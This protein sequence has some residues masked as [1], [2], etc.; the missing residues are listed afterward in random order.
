MRPLYFL[1]GMLVGLCAGVSAFLVG[2][3]LLI[4]STIEYAALTAAYLVAVAVGGFLGFFALRHF[5]IHKIG[6]STAP[7]SGSLVDSIFRLIN[8]ASQ[9]SPSERYDEAN[10]L[11]KSGAVWFASSMGFYTLLNSIVAVVAIF[12]G[13]VASLLLFQQNELISEQ[14][15]SDLLQAVLAE[16]ARRSIQ[17]SF[18]NELV[19]KIKTAHLDVGNNAFR[20]ADEEL[21]Q[22][23]EQTLQRLQ[24]Y[25]V[26]DFDPDL[27]GLDKDIQ[28][29]AS[30]S[31]LSPEKGQI[32]RSLLEQ[33]MNIGGNLGNVNFSFV[34]YRDYPALM[35]VA[36]LS[37]ESG[38]EILARRAENRHVKGANI[39]NEFG[40]YLN[41][42]RA[43]FSRS[44]LVDVYF[45]TRDDV[46][47]SQTKFMSS[48][49]SI[50]A[51]PI[52]H[53]EM[54]GSV[55][56]FNTEPFPSEL[57]VTLNGGCVIVDGKMYPVT[58][59]MEIPG[60]HISVSHGTNSPDSAQVVLSVRD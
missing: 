55:L 7:T 50:D 10:K 45:S 52:G 19:T 43:D 29:S 14:K 54:E 60:I 18:T 26:A 2:S 34:D 8:P 33:G 32:L 12:A 56:V 48:I 49:V 28:E 5:M 58:S 4:S 1:F 15:K 31:F 16:S 21:R 53:F 24:P 27:F 38:E 35:T 59:S 39:L 46:V 40:Q 41:I 13:T 20:R 57:T 36:P 6:L 22:E 37:C 30:V 42:S 17:F 11:V 47:L 51:V 9:I 44:E 3:S 25:A 23:I